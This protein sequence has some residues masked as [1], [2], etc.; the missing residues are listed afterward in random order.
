MN[1]PLIISTAAYDG[2]D[3]EV[4]FRE[5]AATGVDLVEV[6]FIEGYTGP[7]TEA[8]FNEKNAARICELLGKQG[9][10]CLSFSS[11]VDL[12]RNGIVDIFKKRMVFARQL[13]ARYII[14]NAARPS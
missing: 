11:H 8:Y 3:L 7:F 14:S 6:A 9:L 1:N 13:G 10:K 12:A 4:A 2:Y 5:I